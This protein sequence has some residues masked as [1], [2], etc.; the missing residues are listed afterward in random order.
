[1][2]F[3][4][5]HFLANETP[6]SK[7]LNHF[8][9]YFLHIPKYLFTSFLFLLFISSI[10]FTQSTFCHTCNG[11]GTVWEKV[12][13]WHY[14]VTAKK[15]NVFGGTDYTYTDKQ[16][17]PEN[18]AKTCPV[19]SGKGVRP[20]RTRPARP[21]VKKTVRYV[22]T[23]EMMRYSYN[24]AKTEFRNGVI[25]IGDGYCIGL[26]PSGTVNIIKLKR[27]EVGWDMVEA[28]FNN[29]EEV[30]D[31]EGN[32]HSY[33]FLSKSYKGILSSWFYDKNKQL[34]FKASGTAKP[35]FYQNVYWNESKEGEVSLYDLDRK[36][37]IPTGG[38]KY[39]PNGD[40]TDMDYDFFKA[41]LFPVRQSVADMHGRSTRAW[42][43]VNRAGKAIVPFNAKEIIDFDPETGLIGVLNRFGFLDRFASDGRVFEPSGEV[44]KTCPDGGE[45]L[46]T[47]KL[48]KGGSSTKKTTVYAYR[49][50]NTGVSFPFIFQ[51]CECQDGSGNMK[52]DI[53]NEEDNFIVN[54]SGKLIPLSG[55]GFTPGRNV[56]PV[57]VHRPGLFYLNIATEGNVVKGEVKGELRYG[58]P[59]YKDGAL[60]FEEIMQFREDHF[61]VKLNGKIATLYYLK[62][63]GYKL[64]KT[65]FVTFDPYNS[66]GIAVVGKNSEGRWGVVWLKYGSAGKT[67]VPSH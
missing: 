48:R 28:G 14:T 29:Y 12:S 54:S 37:N 63:S 5:I 65:D 36:E 9:M 1:M 11:T 53:F 62:D 52:V 44:F 20:I 64:V 41:N 6:S 25:D 16:L 8:H 33:L 18:H 23:A 51:S 4:R 45:I 15:K 7:S 19:C 17:K 67:L 38:R 32:F 46:K 61:M 42:G 66:N 43:V 47:Q 40:F 10:L 39:F 57:Q 21:T 2:A 49:N 3:H 26:H 58:I 34:I 50:E 22:T 56:V 27:N 55:D 59:G 60:L 31:P 35:T 13:Y 24:D 30:Y